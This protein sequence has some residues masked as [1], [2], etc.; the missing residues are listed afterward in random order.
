MNGEAL[1]S[2]AGAGGG[3]GRE[4]SIAARVTRNWCLVEAKSNTVDISHQGVSHAFRSPICTSDALGKRPGSSYP[5]VTRGL[6]PSGS[7]FGGVI[8]HNI[9]GEKDTRWS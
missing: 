9:L 8:G 7:I 4:L 5:Y 6:Q 3:G 2:S 1:R